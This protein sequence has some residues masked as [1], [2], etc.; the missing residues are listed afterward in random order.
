MGLRQVVIRRLVA[1]QRVELQSF[2]HV[3]EEAKGLEKVEEDEKVE[4]LA[5]DPAPQ[6]S[7]VRTILGEATLG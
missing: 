1:L 5:S 6:M 2:S 4:K 7:Q 3:F